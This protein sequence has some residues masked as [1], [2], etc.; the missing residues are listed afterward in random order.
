M[1]NPPGKY[2]NS[3]YD[4]F[5]KSGDGA[6]LAKK[7]QNFAEGGP[8]NPSVASLKSMI[9][10]MGL[11]VPTKTALANRSSGSSSGSGDS[12]EYWVS[13]TPKFDEHGM[14]M[15][16]ALKTPA[17]LIPIGGMAKGGLVKKGGK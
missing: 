11:D 13:N 17:G 6:L 4:D 2:K 3:G 7:R 15:R 12:N 8:A 5:S 16:R 10:D 14:P 1:R 9:S